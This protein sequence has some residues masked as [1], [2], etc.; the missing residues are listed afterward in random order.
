MTDPIVIEPDRMNVHLT[1]SFIGQDEA[2][3]NAPA[4]GATI[5]GPGPAGGEAPNDD[6]YGRQRPT[7]SR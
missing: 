2:L 7:V 4:P 6:H 5:P 1:P 3:R